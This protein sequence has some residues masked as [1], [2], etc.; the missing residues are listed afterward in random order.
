MKTLLV[1]VLTCFVASSAWAVV[2]PDPDM[3]GIYFDLNADDNCIT[4]PSNTPFFAYLILTN[5]TAPAINAYE[6]SFVNCVCAGIE[7][8]FFML[9]SNIAHNVVAGV[10]VGS[11]T[12]LEGQY[13]VGL[14]E[15]LPT[16]EATLLH[17]WEFMMGAVLPVQMYIGPTTVPSL[18]GGLPVVQNAEGSILMTVGTSTGGPEIPVATMNTDCVVAT[19]NLT[20]GDIKALYR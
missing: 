7:N 8:L 2:D 20:W 1:M 11:H 12:A 10:D 17:S 15:A 3:L 4:V 16:T 5:S 13:I 14:A 18:P 6:F 9:A 19:E